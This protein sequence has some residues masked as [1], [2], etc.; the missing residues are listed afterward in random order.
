ME[1]CASFF[2]QELHAVLRVKPAFFLS[3]GPGSWKKVERKKRK[4]KGK[5]GEKKWRKERDL[6]FD[7]LLLIL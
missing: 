6:P 7:A 5:G 4:R 1:L 2:A 3:F